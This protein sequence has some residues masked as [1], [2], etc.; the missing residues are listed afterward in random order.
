MNSGSKHSREANFYLRRETKK[1]KYE[2]IIIFAD[3]SV[4]FLDTESF[5]KIHVI[6]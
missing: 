5:R 3:G 6:Q 2:N 4:L 1:T